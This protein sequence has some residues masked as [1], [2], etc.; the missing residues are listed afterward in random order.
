LS[1]LPEASLSFHEKYV[2]PKAGLVAQNV[3]YPAG[4]TYTPTVAG[5]LSFFNTESGARWYVQIYDGVDWEY[6]ILY[7]HYAY[8]KNVLTDGTNIRF[9]TPSGYVS[10]TFALITYRTIKFLE[11]V[12][13]VLAAGASLLLTKVGFYITEYSANIRFDVYDGTAWQSPYA[14]AAPTVCYGANMRLRNPTTE[15][16]RYA[17]IRC[18]L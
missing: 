8:S 14:Q 3:T 11:Y 16:K 13:G 18:G 15:S 2:I 7:G 12:N 4:S 5:I 6:A 10:P 9:Y 1:V 17:Y